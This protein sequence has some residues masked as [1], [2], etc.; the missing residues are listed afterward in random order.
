MEEIW[1]KVSEFP[2]LYE[3]SNLGKVRSV[4]RIIIGKDGISYP[5]KGKI[6]SI[7]DNGSGYFN[8]HLYINNKMNT[9]Y[10]HR[11]VALEFVDNPNP[12]EFIY[13]NHKDEDKSNNKANNLEWCNGT[14]NNLYGSR[15]ERFKIS[16]GIKVIKYNR[17]F[18]EVSRYN[19]M[20]DAAREN[21]LHVSNISL[22]CKDINRTCGGF[23]WAYE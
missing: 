14:Y 23:H 1:K 10:V 3:V 18:E 7:S 15:L 19:S 5:K 9:R 2:E 20:A 11:L 16:R 13:I 17:F 6:L 12:K 21:K 8:V 4:D 22:A